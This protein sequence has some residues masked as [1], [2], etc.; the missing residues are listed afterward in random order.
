MK[1]AEELKRLERSLEIT[2]KACKKAMESIREGVTELEIHQVFRRT[3]AEEDAVPVI[4]SVG[5]GSHSGFPHVR[6]GD[7]KVR[8]GDLI[9]FDIGCICNYYHSDT[10][11]NAV[12]G[13]P[14]GKQRTY[15]QAI[16][17]GADRALELV[18][19]GARASEI[20][21]EAVK[22]VREAGIPHFRRTHVGHGI[23]I[24]CYDPPF[25]SPI[26]DHI[27]EEGMVVNIETPYY[28]M[29]FGGLAVEDTLVVTKDGYRLLTKA[30][31][32]VFVL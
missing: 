13:E 3:I 24:E 5:A 17:A 16:K 12:V 26:S 29:G 27:L 19:P 6:A 4:D 23:G 18:R 15:Y 22:R 8:K 31:C 28:E 30:K 21:E 1:S 7:Y 9:R 20:F 32:D 10:A 14:N 11:R 25:L 2:E